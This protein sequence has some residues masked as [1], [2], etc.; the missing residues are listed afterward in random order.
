MGFVF[1]EAN[2]KRWGLA[3]M[4]GSLA[5][6]P[7]YGSEQGSILLEGGQHGVQE[8]QGWGGAW[9]GRSRSATVRTGRH[10]VRSPGPQRSST[11]ISLAQLSLID[12]G[13]DQIIDDVE[14]VG[15]GTSLAVSSTLLDL[16]APMTAAEALRLV[17][18]DSEA[19]P[20]GYESPEDDEEGMSYTRD[21]RRMA[22]YEDEDDED[23]A[24]VMGSTST[25]TPRPGTAFRNRRYEAEDDERS[26]LLSLDG[27]DGA[28][29]PSPPIP[30]YDVAVGS[31]G[32][33]GHE[34]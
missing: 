7:P 11:D 29:E 19:P 3:P 5:P 27:E 15:E 4:T 1:I 33:S 34:R 32:G 2:V 20:P 8:G 12:S 23:D 14:D 17:Q 16:G 9:G 26:R 13:E 6:P 10:Q 24:D 25:A 18:A 22:D 28:R 31:V 21:R 30:S